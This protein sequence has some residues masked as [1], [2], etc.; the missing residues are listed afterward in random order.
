[1]PARWHQKVGGVWVPLDAPVSA[2][3]TMLVGAAS[4]N[5]EDLVVDVAPLSAHRTYSSGEFPATFAASPAGDDV[6]SG[7]VSIYSAKPDITATASGARDA[8]ITAFVNSIPAGH[9]V[10][11][12]IWHEHDAKVRQGTFTYGEWQA[13]YRRFVDVV[14]AVGRS[15]TWLFVNPTAWLWNSSQTTH[16]PEEVWPGDSYVDVIAIDGYSDSPEDLFGEPLA[17]A[18]AHSKPWAIAECGWPEGASKPGL[19]TDT[20][21]YAATN[22]SAGRPGAEFLCWFDS[23]VGGGEVGATPT[24]GTDPASR[25]AAAAACQTY[26]R[27]PAAYTL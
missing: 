5:F 23:A 22:G 16:T 24:P 21:A 26:A 14:R 1:M 20:A 2:A 19:I 6:S 17:F 7:R 3:P 8:A 15:R 27:D 12:T 13:A 10:F 11:L 9:A 18:R 4:S 25:A